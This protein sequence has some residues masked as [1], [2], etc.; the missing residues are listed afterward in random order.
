MKK[1]E[2]L[3]VDAAML[4]PLPVNK[5]KVPI[6]ASGRNRSIHRINER[7]RYEYHKNQ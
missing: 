3:F 7:I 1:Q 6:T 4:G 2:A 5:H